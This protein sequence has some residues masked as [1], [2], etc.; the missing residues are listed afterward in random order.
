MTASLERTPAQEEETVLITDGAYSR[1]ENRDLAA[2]KNIHLVNTGLSGKP[3][4]DIRTD[5]VFN[6]EGINVLEC[7]AGY[8]P[9]PVDTQERSLHDTIRKRARSFYHFLLTP[10]SWEA[11]VTY[12]I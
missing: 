8:A 3:V 6:Q 2:E 4:D 12:E 1:K 5:F 9:G 10:T 7:P 11:Y